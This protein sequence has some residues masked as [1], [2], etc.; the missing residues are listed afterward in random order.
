MAAGVT[1]GA[2]AAL[3][4]TRLLGDLLYKTSPRDPLA[5]AVA[6]AVITLVSLAACFVPAYRAS[7][8]DPMRA[9]RNSA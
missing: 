4:L 6:F 9:L 8:T 2:V 3:S 1:L 7:Q 5:F